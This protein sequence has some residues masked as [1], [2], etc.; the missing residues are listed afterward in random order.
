MLAELRVTYFPFPAIFSHSEYTCSK[1]FDQADLTEG[2]SYD[3]VSVLRNS[4]PEVFKGDASRKG[5]RAR[6]FYPGVKNG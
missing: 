1:T 3:F 6:D 5:T 4:L 2:T